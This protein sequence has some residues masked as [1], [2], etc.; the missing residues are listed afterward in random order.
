MAIDRPYQVLLYYK[1]HPIENPEEFTNEHR[2]FCQKNN[3]VGRILIGK[4]GINGTCAG[5][6][7]GISAYK[8]Y[9]HSKKGFED[10]WF[11]EHGVEKLPLQKLKVQHKPE[12][13]ALGKDVDMKK[14]GKFLSPEEFHEMAKQSLTDDSIVLF[15]GR[16]E[17]E[18]RVGKFRNA[19]APKVRFFRELKE[20]IKK[21]DYESLKNKKV[22]T[23][24]TGGIR[25]EKA[26]ALLREEGFENVYQ[27]HGGIYNYLKHYP[28]GLFDG[29]CFVFDDR[30]QITID[31]DNAENGDK[32]P[33]HKIISCC[34]FCNRKSNRIVNDERRAIRYLRICCVE[35]DKAH[36]ISRIRYGNGRKD[37]L[38]NELSTGN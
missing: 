3:L 6:P 25:C 33:E 14:T 32:A 10:M 37:E 4:E 1:F 29:T 35:C 24:C 15:D 9:V 22:L 11:K 26:T 30:M 2:E 8:S 13:V 18:S 20:E 21:K 27:L 31:K 7:D 19:V 16:N 5:L 38:L 17:I 12:I 23:Y 36:D 34:E 28:N